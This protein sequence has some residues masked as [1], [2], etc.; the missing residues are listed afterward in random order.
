MG[1]STALSLVGAIAGLL[2]PGRR[3]MAVVRTMAQ[4]SE[5]REHELHGAPEQSLSL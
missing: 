2:L 5:T 4:P 3:D 1:V